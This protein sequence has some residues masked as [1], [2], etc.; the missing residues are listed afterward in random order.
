MDGERWCGTAASRP[1]S[2]SACSTRSSACA[3]P[4]RVP[5]RRA[6]IASVEG[7]VR[8]VI[9]WREYVWGMYRLGRLGRDPRRPAGPR[10]PGALTSRPDPHALHLRRLVSGLRETG[11]AHHIERLMLYG[12]LCSCSACARA[13]PFDWFH[14]SFVDGY[15]WVMAPNVE[16][17][18]RAPTAAA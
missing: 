13:R 15:Q 8:Q 17:M 12:N 11:Y 3:R 7:F 4:R 6:P 9:G 18:A 10:A 5:R 1:R 14:H 16:G 2:T